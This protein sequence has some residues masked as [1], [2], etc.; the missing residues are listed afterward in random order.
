MFN[1]ELLFC[2][3]FLPLRPSV[4]LGF[5]SRQQQLSSWRERLCVGSSLA[6]PWPAIIVFINTFTCFFN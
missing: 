3:R 6:E 1:R 5:I 2:A 4:K